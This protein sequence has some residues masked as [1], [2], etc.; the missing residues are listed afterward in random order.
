MPKKL[1]LV[2]D[3]V[4]E[5]NANSSGSDEYDSGEDSPGSLSDFI[6]DT[7]SNSDSDDDDS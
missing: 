2:D 7:S 4:E 5:G 3:E 6:V 1:D